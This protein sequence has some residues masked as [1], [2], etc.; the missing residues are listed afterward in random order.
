MNS[1][2]PEIFIS[3]SHKDGD[4]LAELKDML[5]PARLL[6]DAWDDTRIDVGARWHDDILAALSQAQIGVLLVSTHFLA[7]P[8]ITSEELP[9]LLEAAKRRGLII[10]WILVNECFYELTW[11]QA[12]QAAN[13]PLRPLRSLDPSS[14]NAALKQI[15]GRLFQTAG[16]PLRVPEAAPTM[17]VTGSAAL[18]QLAPGA[19]PLATTEAMDSALPPMSSTRVSP[20]DGAAFGS[21]LMGSSAAQIGQLYRHKPRIEELFEIISDPD[22]VPKALF[23]TEA[24]RSSTILPYQL[25]Y[26][27]HREGVPDTQEDLRAALADAGGRL[28][29]CRRTGTGKTREVAELSREL[30][31][32]R[33][34]ICVARDESDPYLGALIE[35]PPEALLDSKVL[36][37]VDNLHARI[38]APADQLPP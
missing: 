12:L 28:V 7:S 32:G 1:S 19:Q 38:Q 25:E 30:C 8:F 16:V 24:R 34:R 2:A 20:I 13:R 36:V 9:R 29:L 26:I 18:D 22:E 31:F 11:L 27:R 37:V 4:V 15:V 3:Y 35:R 5:A 33:W 6:L 17:A 23:R 14:R 10:F 21:A